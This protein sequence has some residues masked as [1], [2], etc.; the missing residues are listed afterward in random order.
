MSSIKEALYQSLSFT[1]GFVYGY[2]AIFLV[3][4]KYFDKIAMAY[5]DFLDPELNNITIEKS[6]SKIVRKEN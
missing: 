4:R 2:I 1:K 3:P 6:D 5:Y